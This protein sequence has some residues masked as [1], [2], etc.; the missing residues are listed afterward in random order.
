MSAEPND[1]RAVYDAAVQRGDIEAV[2]DLI[3]QHGIAVLDRGLP[4]VLVAA[5]NRVRD[6][7]RSEARHPS[8]PL[9]D[10][11][12]DRTD[13]GVEDA[14]RSMRLAARAERLAEALGRLSDRDAYVLWE[15]ARG[16]KDP[17]IAQGFVERGWDSRP[18]DRATIRKRRERATQRLGRSY[19]AG[20][21]VPDP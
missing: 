8:V 13:D 15:S 17:E 16:T 19:R 3:A 5:R 14:L 10:S 2:H 7:L 4:Y 12:E 11:E 9:G 18:V 1:W 6:R 20:L 21:I